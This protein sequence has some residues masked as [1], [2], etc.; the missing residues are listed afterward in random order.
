MSGVCP[1]GRQDAKGRGLAFEACCGRFLGHFDDC[2]APDAEALMR[3]RY[4]A[5]VCE[6]APYL[7]A[8]WH[9]GHRP[10]ALE[11]E[12]GAKWLGLTV[13]DFR[14]TG[15]GRAEVEFIARY[16]IAGRAVRLHERSRFIFEG[17]RWSYLDGDQF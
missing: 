15:E 13:K 7:L 9:P 10:A 14:E 5:F 17:G 6:D 12:P 4:S 3:S 1:C 11:F 8:T 2:P 16:R